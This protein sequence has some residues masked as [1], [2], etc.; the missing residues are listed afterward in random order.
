MELSDKVIAVSKM[1]R[2][3]DAHLDE[4][5]TLDALCDAAGYSKHYAM[6]I[7]K[8]LTGQTPFETIRALRLTRAAQTLRD[9][10]GT[11]GDA[12]WESSFSSHDGFTRAFAKRFGI[13]PQRY[14]NERPPVR[15]FS[16]DS[17]T[18]YYILK[19]EKHMPTESIAKIMTV[20]ALERPARKLIL[21]RSIK[22][23]HYFEYCEEMGCD[24]EGL[25]SS[26][27]EALP[28]SGPA[29]LTLPPNLIT[30]GT[31]NTA[32]GLEVPLDYDK[33]IP[34]GYEITELPPCILLFF[35]G[36]PFADENDF[37]HAIGTLWGLMDTYDPKHYGWEYAPELAPYFNFGAQS[38]KG[39]LMARPVRKL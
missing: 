17:I 20:T 24:W 27:P 14:K 3:I 2:Y 32:S 30:S 34:D 15:Y 29:L 22:A 1:Q 31:G 33:P 7:F 25:F 39:A 11:V 35:C 38:T 4:E 12:A 36:A 6:R 21:L 28:G 16:Q 10:G 37:G 8:E 5:I 9:A 23:S 26:I 18:A 19:G 13:T